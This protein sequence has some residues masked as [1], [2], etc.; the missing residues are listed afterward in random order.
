MSESESFASD[1]RLPEIMDNPTLLEKDMLLKVRFG[2][3]GL[4]SFQMADRDYLRTTSVSNP[5]DQQQVSWYD[6]RIEQTNKIFSWIL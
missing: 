5:P 4:T 1:M 2:S 3:L 6:D